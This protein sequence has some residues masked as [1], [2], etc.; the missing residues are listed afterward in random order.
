M[1]RGPPTHISLKGQTDL[2]SKILCSVWNTRCQNSIT[3]NCYLYW[4]FR[5]YCNDTGIGLCRLVLLVFSRFSFPHSK[6][7]SSSHTKTLCHKFLVLHKWSDYTKIKFVYYVTAIEYASLNLNMMRIKILSPACLPQ[8][9]KCQSC[10]KNGGE[11][12]KLIHWLHN[13]PSFL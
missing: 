5:I 13:L 2:V 10:P 9:I 3:T 12:R 8:Y 4:V 6:Y 1:S 7:S 11:E